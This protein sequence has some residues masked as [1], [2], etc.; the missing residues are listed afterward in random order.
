M[1]AAPQT[2]RQTGSNEHAT[3][4]HRVMVALLLL[5]LVLA[6]LGLQGCGGGDADDDTKDTGPVDCRAHPE[7]CR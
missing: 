1:R 4:W 5:H 7:L 3:R 6:A 2:G